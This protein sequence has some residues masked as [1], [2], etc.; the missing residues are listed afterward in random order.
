MRHAAED[1][2]RLAARRVVEID[3][4]VARRARVLRAEETERGGDGCG[5]RRIAEEEPAG[6]GGGERR[7]DDDHARPRASTFGRS[8]RAT[9][10][11]YVA[12]GRRAPRR[13]A[14]SRRRACF[15]GRAGEVG[16]ERAGE[17]AFEPLPLARRERLGRLLVQR[18]GDAR[19]TAP[20]GDAGD[21]DRP[22]DL[23][24]PDLERVADPDL[25]RGL[26]PLSADLDVAAGDGVGRR[27]ARLEEP[28]RPEPPVD[29]NPL[30]PVIFAAGGRSGRYGPV[31]RASLTLAACLSTWGLTLRRVHLTPALGACVIALVVAASAGAY[32]AATG[33]SSAIV[34]CVSHK[35][36]GLYVAR[37]CAHGD[38][39]LTWSVTGPQG[40]AGKDGAAGAAGPKGDTG[41]A[42]SPGPSRACSRRGSRCAATGRA[43]P[44]PEA[45]PSSRS[46]SASRLRR[47]PRSTTCPAPRQYPPAAREVRAPTRRRS[48]GTS[49]LYSNGFPLNTS[50]PKVTGAANAWGTLFT[51]S[52]TSN[53]GF[54]D[55][56][57][58]AATSP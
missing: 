45:R 27:A 15:V 52:S 35:G 5:P 51:V 22:A 7:A 38:R 28:R 57:T 58:W 16:A 18:R 21:D 40:P 29:P 14:S 43:D 48:R 6:D 3:A 1:V 25:L 39:V 8:R 36:G 50:G 33:S 42:G 46:R 49:A 54:A 20:V 31:V 47:P 4:L 19:R 26:H 56:G 32:A 13:S 44:V 9:G 17:P 53:A 55:G 10:G 30:H 11:P 12:G 2:E 24:A 34:A 41:A 37:T 23:A